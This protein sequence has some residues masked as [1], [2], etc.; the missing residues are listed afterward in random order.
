MQV[1]YQPPRALFPAVIFLTLF[2]GCGTGDP[3]DCH[4]NLH[5]ESIPGRSEL[6]KSLRYL[7]T[8]DRLTHSPLLV[9]CRY[10][11]R[12]APD[13]IRLTRPEDTMKLILVGAA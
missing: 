7:F 3:A 11:R 13:S 12:H 8:Y 6:R 5:C 1:N 2:P 9:S 4:G 10:K